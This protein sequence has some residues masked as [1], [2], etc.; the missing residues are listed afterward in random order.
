MSK[1]Y[2]LMKREKAADNVG[3]THP[4]NLV[5]A[6]YDPALLAKITTTFSQAGFPTIEAAEVSA[7]EA[8][9]ALFIYDHTKRAKVRTDFRLYRWWILD[10]TLPIRHYCGTISRHDKN[11]KLIAD[12]GKMVPLTSLYPDFMAY[13]LKDA[14]VKKGKADFSKEADPSKGTIKARAEAE[15]KKAMAKMNEARFRLNDF[16]PSRR[17]LDKLP[18]DT[19]RVRGF[20]K[21]SLKLPEEFCIVFP[22]TRTRFGSY[23]AQKLGIDSTSR[24]RIWAVA[25]Y[26]LSWVEDPRTHQAYENYVDTW[27]I[28]NSR[29]EAEIRARLIMKQ[30]QVFESKKEMPSYVQYLLTTCCGSGNYLY[31]YRIYRLM[32]ASGKLQPVKKYVKKDAA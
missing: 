22:T 30:P 21:D 10:A 26:K 27:Q 17:A 6:N 8:A 4:T 9:R 11:G 18:E 5:S 7:K 23:P 29:E 16:A 31:P 13:G 2:V 19:E 15:T 12:Y 32:V 28:F 25:S 20:G 14:I 3:Y 1:F 24:K